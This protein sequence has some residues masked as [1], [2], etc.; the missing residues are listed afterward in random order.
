MPSGFNPVSF[1]AISASQ[2]WLLGLTPCSN[3]V[4]TSIVR[5]TNGGSSFVGLPAPASPIVQAGGSSASGINTL[6][7]ADTLDGYAFATGGGGAFWDTHDGG[8]QW[9]QPGFLSG[10]QLL[11]FGTGGGYAL[12]LVGACTNG[13]C[14]SVVL[15]RSPVGS[16]QW[17]SVSVPV[18][19]GANSLVAMTVHGSD[20]WFSVTTALTSANQLLV[21]GTVSGNSFSTYASPCFSG[22]GG[23]IEATSSQ[24]LWAV[25]PTGMMAQAFRSTDSG[26]H[27]ATLSVG[28]L[29]NSAL[30]APASDSS[31]VIEPT[32]QGQLLRTSNGGT[33]W[34]SVYPAGSGAF[35]WTWAG[36]TDSSTGSALRL[37]SSPPAGWPFPNGPFPEQLWRSS[38]GGMTWSG[39]VAIH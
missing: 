15:E 33:S 10:R 11:A 30:L 3:P 29:E 9:S 37:E 7:F 6:R 16:D 8:A 22:L 28:E 39:P 5:T 13:S 21:A 26:A 18:P 19:A 31:A 25:C 38:D 27:W 4:C 34:Q 14:S 12:A 23:T 1:T 32:D 17:A 20:V 36:F 2:Y 35:S 24:V